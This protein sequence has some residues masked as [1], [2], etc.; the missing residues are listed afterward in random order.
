MFDYLISATA[1]GCIREPFMYTADSENEA[2]A[3]VREEAADFF[4]VRAEHVV[5][6]VVNT[7][8]SF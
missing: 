4:G 2:L 8:P 7:T 3:A 1:P 5:L 6:K